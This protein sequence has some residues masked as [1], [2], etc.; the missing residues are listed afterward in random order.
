LEDLSHCQ[1]STYGTKPLRQAD[2]WFWR[3]G[4]FQA[5][6]PPRQKNGLAQ[7]SISREKRESRKSEPV[8]L[9]NDIST[10]QAKIGLGKTTARSLGSF[11]LE[12]PLRGSDQSLGALTP[13]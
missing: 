12:Q 8:G 5:E 4:L 2:F 13:G 9:A 1:A 3:S 11:D 10:P 6:K 7:R